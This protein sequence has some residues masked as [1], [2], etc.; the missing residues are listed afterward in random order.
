MACLC[1]YVDALLQREEG[2]IL[3]GTLLGF[4]PTPL[5]PSTPEGE[6][7]VGAMEEFI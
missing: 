4:A 5:S 3:S 2:G 1:M 6:I 7:R